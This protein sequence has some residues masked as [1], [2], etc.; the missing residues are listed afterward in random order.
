MYQNLLLTVLMVSLL[1][2]VRAWAQDDNASDNDDLKVIE[3]ELEKSAT[4]TNRKRAEPTVNAPPAA[5]KDVDFNTLGGLAPF[6]EVSV[7]QK[8]YLQKTGRLQFFGGLNMVTNNP[9]FDTYGVVGKA[10]YFL[11]ETWGLEANYFNLTTSEAKSTK[12]L[13]Q[14]QNVSTDNLIYPKSYIGL[15]VMWF[16]MYGKFSYFNKKIIPFDMYF[17]AGYGTTSTQS[18]EKPG[19]LHAGTGQIFAITKGFALRWDFSWHQ[20]S[21][22]GIDSGNS[23]FNFLFLSLGAS[24]FFPEANYR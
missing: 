15:D 2:P 19:T 12:E 20:F 23:S 13:K 24:F 3:V 1:S 18:D 17:S 8:R 14:F 22:K 16:P 4:T 5:S 21:A 6:T 11:N 9:F 7:L 10:A